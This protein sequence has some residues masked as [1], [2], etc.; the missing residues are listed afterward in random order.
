MFSFYLFSFFSYIIGKHEGRKSPA[1][2]EG[3]QQW[4]GGGVGEK[5]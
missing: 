1:Q 3:W 2:G 5:G 4:E